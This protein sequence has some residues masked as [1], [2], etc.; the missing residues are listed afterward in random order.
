MAMPGSPPITSVSGR[1]HSAMICCGRSLGTRPG[2]TWQGM[3]FLRL[4]R[5]CPYDEIMESTMPSSNGKHGNGEV[6]TAEPAPRI[7][8]RPRSGWSA[9]YAPAPESVKVVI[10]PRYGH[11]INGKWS[12]PKAAKKS[13]AYFETINP[14]K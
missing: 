10:A 1:P 8:V 11:F 12:D 5:R 6:I 13:D 3:T 4:E 14:A 9:E 2:G 7:S